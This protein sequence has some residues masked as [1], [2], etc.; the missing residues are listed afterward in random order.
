MA[1]ET[2]SNAASDGRAPAAPASGGYASWKGTARFEIVGCLGSGGMGV[3]YEVFDKQRNER[4]AL[5]TLHRFDASGL[6]RF[7]KEFRTLS[8]VVHPNLVQLHELVA[9]ENDEVLFTMELVEG[10]DFLS[11]VRRDGGPAPHAPESAIEPSMQRVR[12]ADDRSGVT[13]LTESAPASGRSPANFD[14]LRPAFRQLVEGVQ[15][16]HAAGKLHRDLKPSNVRVTPEGRVVILDFGVATELKPR[17]GGGAEEEEIVGTAMYMAPEQASGEPPAAASDW[18]SV[19]ALLYEAMVGEPPF[20]GSAMEVLTLK[21]TVTPRSPA[22]RVEGVPDD[23]DALCMALLSAEPEDRPGANEILR[24]LGSRISDRAPAP[25][26]AEG[27]ESAALVGREAHL[28]ALREAFYATTDGRSIAVRVS[29]FSGLGKSAVVH[30]FLDTLEPRGDVLV[31]RGRAYERESVPYKAVD[32]VIDALSKHLVDEQ[33][34]QDPTELPDGIGALAHLFPVLRRV[35]SIEEVPQQT[36]DLQLLRQRAFGVFRE[37]IRVLGR[38]QRVVVFIDDVQWGDS[39]SAALL[40]D[41]MR[42]PSAPPLLLV[43]T[44]RAED[45]ATSVFLADLRQRWPADAEVRD[46]TVGPLEVEDAKR[47]ALGL[48]G[49]DSHSAKQTADEIARE[50]GGSP[51][52]LEELARAASAY[53]RMARGESLLGPRS[54]VS[55]EQMLSDRASRLPEDARRFLELVAVGGRPLPVT[56]ISAAAKA[57]D[58]T[59]RI[60]AILRSRRFV[61]SSLRDGCD[62]IEASHGRIRETIFAG[63]AAD[64][65]R[66]HHAELARVLEATPDADPE[67]I[68]AH[69]LGAGEGKRAAGYAEKAAERAIGKLAF[70]QAARLFEL[71]LETIDPKSPDARRLA[72]RL[73]ESNEWAGHAE[74]AARAYLRAADGAPAL[75]RAALESAATAQLIAAG[76]IDESAIVGR[77]VLEAVGRKA[78]SS[79]LLTFLFIAVYRIL[80]DFLLRQKLREARALTPE[81]RVRM[82]ALHALARGLAVV[83]PVQA[84]YVKARYIVDALRSG[85]RT[86]IILAAAAEASSMTSRGGPAGKRETTLFALARRLTE[87]TR[88]VEGLALFQVTYGICLYLRGEWRKAGEMLDE[89]TSRLLAMRR[90]QANA[91]VFACYALIYRGQLNEVK[92]R[93]AHLIADAERRGDLYTSVN[94]RASHPIATWLAS[95]D[96]E[97][98]RKHLRESMGQWSKTRYLVQ[99]WQAM[100]WEAETDLYAGD[101]LRAWDRLQRDVAALQKSRL[102]YVQLLAVLTHFIRGRAAI[103]S[104]DVLSGAPRA[105]RLEEARGSHRK[106]EAVAMPWASALASMLAAC[107]AKAEGREPAA[108]EDLLARAAELTQ[109]ADMPLH[110][111]AARHQRGVLRG[112]DAGKALLEDAEKAM[113]GLGVRVPAKYAGALMPGRW[114]R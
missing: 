27:P 23:L 4:V 48:L 40:V 11:F 57:G 32:S 13:L 88:D 109:A 103:A 56:T 72:K 69:L 26:T 17:R 96:V 91:N 85:N 76:L 62:V 3:V 12:S 55:L 2:S 29:G 97:G 47:M 82:G 33:R 113:T 39:D 70:A 87:E 101:G 20:A 15:A 45:D 52:L 31:L 104:L 65:A 18:Y 50:S 25:R 37:L 30:H 112:G 73:A 67:A 71:T 59:G 43:T 28:R 54:S 58:S 107:I 80:A 41:L 46:L 24:R 6:Y 49:S 14:K 66:A 19:G 35:P 98:A 110:A 83:D 94:L 9:S 99:H 36:G 42:Q 75:E 44:H 78:P 100:L 95:D 63:L 106:L 77:R 21:Y 64:T 108:V 1:D 93:A 60:V 86:H 105:R 114:K 5:K 61:R 92:K 34:G 111:E 102:L 10:G 38:Q 74:K 51:F 53:H 79:T 8:D 81:E 68:A 90:W 89:V 84:M 7:K 16:L 22:A